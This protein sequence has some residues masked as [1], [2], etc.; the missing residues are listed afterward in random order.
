M[1]KYL[2][3][4]WFL[5]PVSLNAQT[6]LSICLEYMTT[7]YPTSSWMLQDD[8]QGVYIKQWNS[9]LAEPTLV[10]AYSNWPIASIWKS[11]QVAEIKSDLITWKIQNVDGD[12]L[13]DAFKALIICINKRLPATN[14]I[15]AVEFKTELKTQLQQ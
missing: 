1:K 5:I 7:N 15:T 6:N 2:L 11:N 10:Q 12:T 8:G 13:A 4:L 9:I 14:K 3:I